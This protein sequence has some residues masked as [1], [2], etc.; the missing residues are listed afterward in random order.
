MLK[1]PTERD[2]TLIMSVFMKGKGFINNYISLKTACFKTLPIALCGLAHWSETKAR[3][4]WQTCKREYQKT[5][6][7][8]HDSLTLYFFGNENDVIFLQGEKFC[9]GALSREEASDFG[10]AALSLLF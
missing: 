10:P 2:R 7:L 6:H 1:I 8:Q 9:S 3:E 4:T 5:K